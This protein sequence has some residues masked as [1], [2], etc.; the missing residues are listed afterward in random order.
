L[1]TR[2]GD[3]FIWAADYGVAGTLALKQPPRFATT[4]GWR[5]HDYGDKSLLL[6]ACLR[7]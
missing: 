3:A 2:P 5:C 1:A 4:P 7:G 6:L